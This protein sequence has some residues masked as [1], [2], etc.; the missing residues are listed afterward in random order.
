[1]N[2]HTKIAQGAV[3]LSR[4][5]FLISS[6]VAGLMFGFGTATASTA[7]PATAYDPSI[8]YSMGPMVL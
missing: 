5:S 6:G 3:D 1:M 8:W 7:A 2:T 4:R